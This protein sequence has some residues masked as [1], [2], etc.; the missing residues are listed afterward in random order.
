ME[1]K[2]LRVYIIGLNNFYI[3]TPGLANYPDLSRPPLYMQHLLKLQNYG[4]QTDRNLFVNII[5]GLP[6]KPIIAQPSLINMPCLSLY[7][8]Q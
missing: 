8:L 6:S 4:I 1:W 2:P 7:G 3:V 5:F